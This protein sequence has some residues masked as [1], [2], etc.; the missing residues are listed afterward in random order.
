MKAIPAPTRLIEVE[1]QLMHD[2]WGKEWVPVVR[3]TAGMRSQAL[4]EPE[5]FA[6]SVRDIC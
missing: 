1:G 6:G 2:K 4:I 3:G 5:T